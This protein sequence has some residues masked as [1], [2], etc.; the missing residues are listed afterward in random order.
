MTQPSAVDVRL[1]AGIPRLCLTRLVQ[2]TVKGRRG[3]PDRLVWTER[4]ALPL[5]CHLTYES[6]AAFSD[7]GGR[8]T[9]SVATLVRST[10]LSRSTV[11]H[12]LARLR[13]TRLI[14]VV[15]QGIDDHG[16]RPNL[17]VLR[18]FWRTWKDLLRRITTAFRAA[19]PSYPQG[20]VSRPPHTPHRGV[21]TCER[22]DPPKDARG[23]LETPGAVMAAARRTTTRP[24]Q[25]DAAAALVSALG[26]V[27]FSER[28]AWILGRPA[29]VRAVLDLLA[30][31]LPAD[32]PEAGG[33]RRRLY[34][35][36]NA[37][38]RRV[39]FGPKERRARSAQPERQRTLDDGLRAVAAYS[40]HVRGPR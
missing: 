20:G 18:G 29:T 9:P 22:P 26:R 35:W 1:A 19:F 28:S 23:H 34:A 17:Y 25:A 36:A 40:R 33:D 38:V 31:P 12:A 16:T 4:R 30:A 39:V 15:P 7:A 11:L 37:A 14:L 8:S 21:N 2:R 32:A 27:V 5:S 24:E 6:L 10:G 13:R 3:Q